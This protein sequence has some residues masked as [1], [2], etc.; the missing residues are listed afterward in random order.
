MTTKRFSI[1]NR[2][3]DGSWEPATLLLD[4]ASSKNETLSFRVTSTRG[5][6]SLLFQGEV[7]K[8]VRRTDPSPT[9]PHGYERL[10][11]EL[12]QGS[13]VRDG[14]GDY[15]CATVVDAEIIQAAKA[16]IREKPKRPVTK[17]ATDE[18]RECV[19]CHA[20]VMSRGS[21]NAGWKGIQMKPDVAKVD[22][23]CLNDPC[24]AAR[25]IAITQAKANWGYEDTVDA[26][27]QQ[28]EPESRTEMG[29][30]KPAGG[31]YG[32]PAPKPF[33]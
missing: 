19:S 8:V 32:P 9:A 13:L 16:M 28:A 14:A 5:R 11:F 3:P 1:M 10:T 30:D 31:K 25:G 20:R 21:D 23:Y 27:Q 2:C 4:S 7:F 15:V 12:G 22:W 33:V 24:I 29:E 26:P 6:G 17:M 18:I